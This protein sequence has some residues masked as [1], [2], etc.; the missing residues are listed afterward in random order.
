VT[1]T[2]LLLICLLVA[3]VLGIGIGVCTWHLLLTSRF[4]RQID[5]LRLTASRHD[6]ARSSVEDD[7]ALVALAKQQRRRIDALEAEVGKLEERHRKQRQR[8]RVGRRKLFERKRAVLPDGGSQAEMQVD[9]QPDTDRLPVLKRRVSGVFPPTLSR[10]VLKPEQRLDVTI[11]FPDR[12]RAGRVARTDD[13]SGTA[14]NLAPSGHED[15]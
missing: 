9:S 8:E 2:S 14:K 4:R 15:D 11:D 13:R 12:P 3:T 1:P 6:N 5:T 7:S 10:Q